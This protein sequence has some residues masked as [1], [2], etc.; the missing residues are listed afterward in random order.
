MFLMYK[1]LLESGK[2]RCDATIDSYQSEVCV[3][4]VAGTRVGL[5]TERLTNGS[6]RNHKV[7][8]QAKRFAIFDVRHME[9]VEVALNRCYRWMARFI[10]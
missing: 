6:H 10:R 4:C 9:V 5:Q 1:F 7:R 2:I 3:W 8:R